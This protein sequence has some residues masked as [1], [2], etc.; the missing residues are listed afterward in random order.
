MNSETKHFTDTIFYQIE[1]TA[2]YAK[3]LGTQLFGKLGLGLTI[4]EFSTLDTILAN[5]ELCQRDLAKLILKDRAN[6]G[7]LLDTLEAKG[8][9]KRELTVKNNRPVKIVSITENGKAIYKETYAKLEPHHRL[10]ENNIVNTDL[11]KLGK[12]LKDLREVL[13]ETVDIDI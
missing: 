10:V 2:R 1:L 5:K 9:V 6:T 12:L 4:E 11:A 7:K 13:E 8:L 3:M